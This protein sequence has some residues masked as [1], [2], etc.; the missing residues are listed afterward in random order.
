MI[1]IYII[2]LFVHRSMIFSRDG[3]LLFV[4]AKNDIRI[5]DTTNDYK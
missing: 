5:L 2:K 4:C 1:N 3:G